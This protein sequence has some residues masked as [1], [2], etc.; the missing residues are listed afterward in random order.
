MTYWTYVKVGTRDTFMNVEVVSFDGDWEEISYP[1]TVPVLFE[2]R[3][4]EVDGCVT[5]TVNL[6]LPTIE[7]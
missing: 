4:K 2:N 6:S 3:P 5:T 1:V 7:I